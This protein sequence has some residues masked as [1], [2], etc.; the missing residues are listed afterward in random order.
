MESGSALPIQRGILGFD[1]AVAESISARARVAL[2]QNTFA[3]QSKEKQ[4]L[5]QRPGPR[6]DH[7]PQQCKVNNRL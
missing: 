6:T 4:K 2:L 1:R 3:T 7:S 5:G